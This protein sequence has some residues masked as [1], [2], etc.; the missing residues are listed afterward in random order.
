MKKIIILAAT[1][2]LSTGAFAQPDAWIIE[3]NGIYKHTAL[4]SGGWGTTPISVNTWNLSVNAGVKVSSHFF[5]GMTA[6][7]GQKDYISYSYNGSSDG[8]KMAALTSAIGAWGRYSY[9]I[10]SW[11]F[12]YAQ[13]NIIKLSTDVKQVEEYAQPPAGIPSDNYGTPVKSSGMG[14]NLYPAV[15]FNIIHGFG[16]NLSLGG[17]DYTTSQPTGINDRELNVT[18]G[19]EFRLGLHKFINSNGKNKKQ[20]EDAGK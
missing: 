6:G 7:Y 2:L 13:A 3:T 19:Q 1:T 10:N 11:L 5:V 15:G 8:V 14:V 9:N 18:L 16:I 4:S 20:K 17:I 12:L